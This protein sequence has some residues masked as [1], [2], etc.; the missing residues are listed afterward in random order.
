MFTEEDAAFLASPAFAKLATLM[1]DGAPQNTVMWFRHEGDSLRMIAPAASQKARNLEL[2]SRVSVVVDDPE[3]GYRYLDIRGR[4]VVLQDDRQARAELRRIAERYIGDSAGDY[5]DSLSAD[6]RVL[7][8][9]RP[10]SVRRHAG[11]PPRAH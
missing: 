2:D 8:V 4:A 9:I 5:V 6:P 7:I 10:D 11:R 1:P 3:N